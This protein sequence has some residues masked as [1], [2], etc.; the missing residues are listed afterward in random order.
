MLLHSPEQPRGERPLSGTERTALALSG[1]AM[2]GLC[3]LFSI[4]S[5][6]LLLVV[7]GAEMIYL[8]GAARFGASHVVTPLIRR[9]GRLLSIFVRSFRRRKFAEYR[10]QIAQKEAPRLFASIRELAERF[11]IAPPKEVSI[12]M[13]ANAWVRLEGYRQGSGRTILA[14]GYDLLAGLSESE[15]QAV[16]AH[17]MGHARFVR[18]GVKRWLDAGVSRIGFITSQLSAHAE[19]FRNEKKTY[20]LAELLL[21]RADFLTRKAARLL[22]T[23]SR[24]DEF[25]ADRIS[26][27]LFGSAS[28]RSALI[29]LKFLNERL[30]RLPWIERVAQVEVQESF[31]R[32]LRREL[33]ISAADQA[34]PIRET[35]HD[36]YS[37]HPSL[38][39]RLAALP[40]DDGRLP[41]A[42][43]GIDFLINP[44]RVASR[45]IAQVNSI[46]AEE[47]QK[48]SKALVRWTRKTKRQFSMRNAQWP[49]PLAVLAGILT[50]SHFL[51]RGSTSAAVLVSLSSIAAAILFWVWGRYRDRIQLPVPR[52]AEIKRAWQS[53]RPADLT[54]QERQIEEE[55]T[56]LVA[57]QDS[58]KHKLAV[59]ADEGITALQHCSYLRAHVAGRLAINIDRKGVEGVLLYL[60][61][62]AGLNLWD[63][64][65]QNMD[66]IHR[67]TGVRTPSTE[68]GVA[69]TFFLAADWPRAE[70][71]LW[72]CIEREPSNTTFR[73]LLA[74]A[75]LQR[76]K[77]Q[78][79][80][81]NAT[82]AADLEPHEVEHT[83]LL[84]RILLDSGRIKEAES[85]L[86]KIE[87][88]SKSDSE[89]AISA[90]RI[91]LMRHQ[92]DAAREMAEQLDHG[93]CNP[94]WLV[95]VAVAFEGA[96]EDQT[97]ERFYREALKK[98]HYPEALLG[99]ARVAAN[100]KRSNEAKEHLISALDIEMSVGPYGRSALELFHHTVGQ[101]MMLDEPRENCMAWIVGFP[102]GASPAALAR[103][104]LMLYATSRRAAENHLQMV[105]EAM[106]PGQSVTP[107][108]QLDWKEA[109]RDQQPARPV[110]EGVQFVL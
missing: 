91:R 19:A 22:A 74:L 69:W 62:A 32:W 21:R 80:I 13:N 93:E 95:G 40:P 47:E 54:E 110:R 76:N 17:E 31:S 28:L 90:I 79:A 61:A 18:R 9:H 36:V 96:R 100:G 73:C 43:P 87:A 68:W 33:S 94:Q 51:E 58:K 46:A 39:D 52:Y 89:I 78:G 103:R 20:H 44:D 3:Y 56:A 108:W 97:A 38:K 59:L 102:A 41:N 63:E 2:T 26:A 65:N 55:L 72:K 60:V 48:D 83:K 24:Q 88:D 53:D 16:L 57:V 98:G 101:L 23:Y 67:S 70:G 81:L 109:P 12:E 6:L 75:Q 35:A 49:A 25:E 99:L 92:F 50:A 10:L 7:L 1:L 5:I 84:T 27:E 34:T 71:L 8:L 66:F 11:E 30:G 85:R 106:R 105:L 86:Q 15:V 4:A 82:M 42:E 29:K 14:V 37:T 64:F 107:T 104:S 45:L 77:L